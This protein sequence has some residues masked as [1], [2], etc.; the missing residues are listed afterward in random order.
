MESEG[1]ARVGRRGGISPCVATR[2]KLIARHPEI[3]HKGF[4]KA[5]RK[6][7][8]DDEEISE[9]VGSFVPDAWAIYP[10]IREM[11]VIEI[12]HTH[13]IDDHKGHQIGTLADLLKDQG[14]NL[15]VAC[16]DVEANLTSHIPAIYYLKCYT[17]LF[18]EKRNVTPK[19]VSQH[20]R[21][22]AEPPSTPEE[23]MEAMKRIDLILNGTITLRPPP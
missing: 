7:F 13:P 21:I 20:H 4:A 18:E 12:I 11:N 3:K 23:L 14:W 6:M 19:A 2:Q 9:A 10:D 22:E 1:Y 16:F 8:P 15:G 17:G 5:I